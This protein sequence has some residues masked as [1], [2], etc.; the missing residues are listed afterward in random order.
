MSWAGPFQY[1]I[2]KSRNA[3]QVPAEVVFDDQVPTLLCLSHL[4]WSFVYQR[5]QHL[6]SR[7]ARDYNVLFHEE[8]IPTEDAE[9]WLEVRPE[10]NGVQVLIPRL[11]A[12]C[13]GEDATRV[14]RQLLDGYLE[15]LGVSDLLLWYYTPM[16][17]AFSDHLAPGLIVYDCMDELSA[18][19]GAPP[20]L[21]EAI[22]VSPGICPN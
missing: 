18:F 12:G 22:C 15:K 14:Q 3:Q 2:G 4:R 9:P 16:S 5:P 21:V 11:P 10:E 8:P 1:D 19:R 20:E 6:M 17:L 13:E 7:F